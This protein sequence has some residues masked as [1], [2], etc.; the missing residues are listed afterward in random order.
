MSRLL[1]I[2][3]VA[4]LLLLTTGGLAQAGTEYYVRKWARAW[5]VPAPVIRGIIRTES[6]G[7]RKAKRLKGGD[8]RRGGAWG[9]M[10][11]T[12]STAGDLVG[13]LR[14]LGRSDVDATLRRWDGT[15]PSLFS[16]DLNILLG[17]YKLAADKAALDEGWPAAVLAYNR[18]RQGARDALEAG[19]KPEEFEYVQKAMA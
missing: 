7:N 12:L 10:Q 4:A 19:R 18:G 8:L 6:R 11:M 13:K 5:N 16:A 15:G 2:I 14:K 1:P 9:L 17:T 3:A